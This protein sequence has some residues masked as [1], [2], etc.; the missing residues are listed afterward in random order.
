MKS[1]DK[2]VLANR[3]RMFAKQAESLLDAWTKAGYVPEADTMYP[4]PESFED[5]VANIV[6][7]ADDV[8]EQ[9][10]GSTY[11]RA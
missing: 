8:S 4:F 9:V 7:W 6:V 11:A 2:E 1:T 10:F 5:V 3:I